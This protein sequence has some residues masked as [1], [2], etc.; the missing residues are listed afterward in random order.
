MRDDVRLT[1]EPRASA[2]DVDTVA[3]GLRAFNEA[4]IGD[5][6]FEPVN[7]FLRD[8]SGQIV[9][10]LIGVIKWRWVYVALL[11]VSDAHRGQGHGGALLSAAEALGTARGCIGVHLDT[12][13]Y[14]ARPFY[15]AHGYQLFGTL[16]GYPPGSRQVH[17]AK[18][19]TSG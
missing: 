4:I 14:L 7:I 3:A 9:G 18:R 12:F 6:G 19:L 11:W 5:P 17:L 13:E 8:A 1:V 16:D 15:E 10:G 2:A